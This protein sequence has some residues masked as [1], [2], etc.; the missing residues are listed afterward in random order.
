[1]RTGNF[2][3]YICIAGALIGAIIGANGMPVLGGLLGAASFVVGMKLWD[4]NGWIGL[5]EEEIQLRLTEVEAAR[6]GLPSRF[7]GLPASK[8]DSL[9][10]KYREMRREHGHHKESL[11]GLR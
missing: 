10:F 3:Q 9:E 2:Y 7:L 4:S 5:S 1:M 6:K 11:N 8:L